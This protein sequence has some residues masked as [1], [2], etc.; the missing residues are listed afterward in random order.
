MQTECL[1]ILIC[2][3]LCFNSSFS[4]IQTNLGH[5]L[6][7]NQL[8]LCIF[9]YLW[10]QT[11]PIWCRKI[12]LR[13]TNK[14]KYLHLVG[15]EM[16]C[17][18]FFKSKIAMVNQITKAWPETEFLGLLWYYFFIIP[19]PLKF[20][21]LR[22]TSFKPDYKN[23][24]SKLLTLQWASFALSLSRQTKQAKLCTPSRVQKSVNLR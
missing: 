2:F 6:W 10:I 17:R 9:K 13:K 4:K 16:R 5:H 21:D 24:S 12:K 7:C 19:C 11:W 23:P 20:S 1:K 22:F 14:I 18:G 8:V 15:H 3:S